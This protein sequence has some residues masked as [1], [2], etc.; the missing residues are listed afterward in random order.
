MFGEID[1]TTFTH[2][3]LNQFLFKMTVDKFSS[4]LGPYQAINFDHIKLE[5]YFPAIERGI[6]EG[7]QDIEK[8]VSNPETPN[9]ENT[10][11]ALE[12]S[13]LYLNQVSN[14]FFNLNSADT[15]PEMQQL[16]QQFSPLLSKYGNDISLNQHLFDRIKVVYE[17]KSTLNLDTEDAMLLD[18]T[19]K[20]FSRNGAL[21]NE[22]QKEELRAIDEKLSLTS[23]KFGENVLAEN[24]AFELHLTNEDDLAGLPESSIEGA[25]QT[26]K[27]KGKTGWV[28][29]LDYP[30]FIP[31]VTY[32]Q[33]RNL[34]ELMTKASGS[35][36][37][38]NNEFNN[39]QNILDLV[40]LRHDRAVL[41]GY[42]S[43]ADYVLEQRMAENQSTVLNFLDNIL[44]AALPF[45][46]QEQEELKELAKKDGVTD[47]QRW[48]NSY[49][50]EKLKMEK[51]DFDSEI[52]RPYFKLENVI[53]G[54]FQVAE[55][56]YGLTFKLDNS[57]P[58]Y[59]PDVLT[60]SVFDENQ[61]FKAL[62][63]ADYF[64]R[65]SKRQGAWMTSYRGQFKRNN[66]VQKPIVSIV[67]NFSKSTES[68]PSLLTFDEVTTLF[69]EFGHALHGLLADGKYESLTGTSVFWDFVE[70][71]S[72][73]LENWCYEKE[74]LDL[75][76]KHY[77]TGETI[78]QDLIDK[79]KKSSNFN[80][81]MQT[82]RQVSL[83]M[84]DMN[85]HTENAIHAKSVKDFEDISNAPT[86]LLPVIP[87]SSTSCSF[88]HIFQGGYSAG[89]YSYKWAEV[90]DA[91]AFEYFQEKGIFNHEVAH[92]FKKHILSA[93]GSEH[94]K[95][96]YKRF[97]GQ[98]ADV[99][100]LLRRSGLKK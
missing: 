41:L 75:F 62:F 65:P 87:T 96:L 10:I 5:D 35:K 50:A 63:Y 38:K 16:A 83:G 81:G 9:F 2:Y 17:Q 52:L 88:S 47:F 18:K 46:K 23:L 8:I 45:A 6:K 74:C 14:V 54:V 72:Q 48:D 90:L 89:Y 56:L 32:S 57:I 68:K 39:E 84:L 78:P 34:R 22:K 86:D 1:I 12:E 30:S 28:F 42:A 92:S 15:N 69:H 36:A 3:S 27:E 7:L 94:P 79:I 25:A 85:W 33:K 29:T 44:K 11:I 37:F 19:Y 13:G 43:H 95:V 98:E 82:V 53:D 73:I 93:G 77:V 99:E 31:F 80:A 66:V 20:S 58:K 59:H 100:A 67:C 55:K 64:P 24:N 71:P 97:R 21:L 40:K 91:D 76:A 70:L 49:Y 60:Y 61:E 51:Y 4:H 26:A